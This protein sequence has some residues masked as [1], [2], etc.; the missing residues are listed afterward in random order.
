MVKNRDRD[1]ESSEYFEKIK[2]VEREIRKVIV[3]QDHLIRAGLICLLTG[4]HLLIEG[5]PGIAKTKFAT[6]LAK[7]ISA[8]FKRIPGT[9]DLLPR[10]VVGF[11][12]M[13]PGTNSWV[14][15]RGPVFTNILL[16]DE[17][18][19]ATPK[20]QSTLLQPMEERMVSMELIEEIARSGGKSE[21][22]LAEDALS[23]PEIFLVLATMNPIDQEGVYPL[24]EPV[25]DRFLMKITVNYPTY[26]EEI[27]VVRR[28]SIEGEKNV[29]PVVETDD[30][31]RIRT[32]VRDIY[33]DPTIDEFAVTIVRMTRPE[34]RTGIERHIYLG[35]SPRAS[36]GL[37]EAARALAFLKQRDYV[38]PRDIL[39]VAHDVLRHRII[40]DIRSERKADDLITNILNEVRGY[41][42]KE[43]S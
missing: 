19:R 29:T 11:P 21:V 2:M 22:N 17:I 7:S 5:A 1:D 18:N 30:L 37:V 38:V 32:F 3:G 12:M 42:E 31:L 14:L 20:A 34:E 15:K 39:A 41:E 26:A 25:K 35:A 16:F 33:V 24:L 4:R 23:L 40:L 27:E 43:I 9:S 10:D 6:V 36:M 28:Q 13:I 8:K